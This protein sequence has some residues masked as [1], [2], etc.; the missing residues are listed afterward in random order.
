MPSRS[1]CHTLT[2]HKH[3]HNHRTRVLLHAHHTCTLTPIPRRVHTHQKTHSVY[4][5]GILHTYTHI[6]TK[7]WPAARATGPSL[8]PDWERPQ[9]SHLLSHLSGPPFLPDCRPPRRCVVVAEGWSSV[10]WPRSREGRGG[11]GWGM[12]Q[13][14]ATP[15][16]PLGAQGAG[17]PVPPLPVGTAWAEA[18]GLAPVGVSQCQG[19]EAWG[20]LHARP[21]A[22]G[23]GWA[24]KG[25]TVSGGRA[26][27]SQTGAPREGRP[28]PVTFHNRVWDTKALGWGCP[29]PRGPACFHGRWLSAVLFGKGRQAGRVCPPALQGAP[30]L[31]QAPGHSGPL[32]WLLLPA[33]LGFKGGI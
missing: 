18:R 8:S 12:P 6:L 13:P 11:A 5:H 21:W 17:W 24:G 15:R 4:T 3:C 14:W 32:H 31:S 7:P 30:T 33:E 20:A 28:A 19:A 27:T 2:G 22:R 26:A 1:L 25:E 9:A 16:E 10:V 23:R 29:S